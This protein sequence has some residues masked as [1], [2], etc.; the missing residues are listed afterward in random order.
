MPRDTRT[1]QA[2][3]SDIPDERSQPSAL[4]AA[5]DEDRQR[6]RRIAERLELADDVT[7]RADLAGELVRA[8]SR[9]EDV[10]ERVLDEAI[11]QHD[12]GAAR[13]LATDR[14]ELRALM[15]AIHDRT[16]HITPANVHAHDPA[17][18]EHLVEE[19]VDRASAVVDAEEAVIEHLV[20]SLDPKER[21][22]LQARVD[23]AHRS[24][25][26]HPHPPKTAVGRLARNVA[27]KLDRAIED[28]ATPQHPGQ[29]VIDG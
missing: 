29:H 18:F 15:A 23:K 5:F 24:A 17:G 11:A 28:V 6:I 22:A 20:R 12:A 3:N 2:R 4:S 21:A 9:N 14:H 19:V 26:E 27:V 7:E 16:S 13:A 10:V 1:T 25:S 8:L